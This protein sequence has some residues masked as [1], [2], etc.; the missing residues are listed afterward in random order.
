MEKVENI[1]NNPAIEPKK[2]DTDAK[3]SAQAELSEKEL[4]GV[5]GGTFDD[6]TDRPNDPNA[7][8]NWQFGAIGSY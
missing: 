5:V 6:G 3:A 8:R 1:E 4:D 2:T 7:P